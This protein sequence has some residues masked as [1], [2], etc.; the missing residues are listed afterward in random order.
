MDTLSLA[1]LIVGLV[2]FIAIIAFIAYFIY[3][4]KA[5][6]NKPDK[7]FQ[8]KHNKER[9]QEESSFDG[10][11]HESAIGPDVK[12]TMRQLM[13]SRPIEE[14]N[15]MQNVQMVEV[16]SPTDRSS[17]FINVDL[18]PS[19]DR[20]PSELNTNHSVSI[21]RVDRSN[22]F[23]NPL[24]EENP[25]P[26]RLVEQTSFEIDEPLP[27]YFENITDDKNFSIVDMQE[28]V[29]VMH[30]VDL[31]QPIIDFT[32]DKL[33]CAEIFNTNK[34]DILAGIS[35]SDDSII[36][37]NENEQSFFANEDVNIHSI[38]SENLFTIDPPL[39]IVSEI[40]SNTNE[41][42]S[43]L[44][45][46]NVPPKPARR[47]TVESKPIPEKL[48]N[49]EHSAAI[50][51]D[52][53]NGDFCKI[54]P[55]GSQD[56]LV[57]S[58]SL[59][60][61]DRSFIK[62]TLN[63]SENSLMDISSETADNT[64]VITMKA[65]CE[66][67][68]SN[69]DISSN[70]NL[71]NDDSVTLMEDDVKLDYFNDDNKMSPP[72]DENETNFSS[73]SL[74]ASTSNTSE[75]SSETILDSFSEWEQAIGQDVAEGTTLDNINLS[76]LIMP[77]AEKYEEADVIINLI[78]DDEKIRAESWS[79]MW[80]D[81]Q[82]ENDPFDTSKFK[83]NVTESAEK[84]TFNASFETTQSITMI[85]SKTE[86]FEEKNPFDKILDEFDSFPSSSVTME[87]DPFDTTK[88]KQNDMVASI[89]SV[90]TSES[91]IDSMMNLDRKEIERSESFISDDSINSKKTI[92]LTHNSQTD[93][94]LQEFTSNII[95]QAQSNIEEDQRNA[96]SNFLMNDVVL[97]HDTS[98]EITSTEINLQQDD[99][100][101]ED[102][103]L[104]SEIQ[105]KTAVDSLFEDFG[106]SYG[107]TLFEKDVLSSKPDSDIIDG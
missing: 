86:I 1:L 23:V 30:T 70:E 49:I 92:V 11:D 59:D 79:D 43:D 52:G 64:S 25:T 90:M 33:P 61:I 17:S 97:T 89:D 9:L 88:Y 84:V 19:K 83:D 34:S 68:N 22:S 8:G 54:S 10:F 103:P 16:I 99:K 57:K 82:E 71:N 51:D 36:M 7:A 67:D 6:N 31:H 24:F 15:F 62:I 95:A 72:I 63:E 105:D 42:N 35:G 37:L 81:L 80:E 28:E 102:V 27:A 85:A 87:D 65:G 29:N 98:F 4:S 47:N 69:D 44:E 50:S 78:T 13:D 106:A 91:F 21:P 39:N 55:F 74:L 58:D 96:E 73:I 32:E 66:I 56:T 93:S 5:A 53:S 38:D 2:L 107:S 26:K 104:D 48:F 20:S 46:K 100:L 3:R 75:Y 45:K 12:I 60:D 40:E 41:K 77:S 101:C 94:M 18:V 76:Q 14:K